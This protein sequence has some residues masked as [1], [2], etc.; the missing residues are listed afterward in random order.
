[1]W[2]PCHPSPAGVPAVKFNYQ[3][4]SRISGAGHVSP[5]IGAH[6]SDRARCLLSRLGRLLYDRLARA[7]VQDSARMRRLFLS[8]FLCRARLLP[9]FLWRRGSGGGGRFLIHS[10]PLLPILRRALRERTLF[11]SSFLCPNTTSLL[12]NS[13]SE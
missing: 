2:L 12:K 9:L 3:P 11:L 5:C 6:D 1:M 13:P 10:L 8:K 4:A 7:P